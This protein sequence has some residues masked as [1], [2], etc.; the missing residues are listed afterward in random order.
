MAHPRFDMSELDHI[1]VDS[2][3][4]AAA[5]AALAGVA[6]LKEVQ[7]VAFPNRFASP[8]AVMRD[9]DG[10][11]GAAHIDSPLNGVAAR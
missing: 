3:L 1:T 5:R 7:T 10:V 6:P 11:I 2:R 4:P 8:Q 9:G